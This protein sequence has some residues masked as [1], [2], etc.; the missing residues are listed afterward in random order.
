MKR[1]SHCRLSFFDSEGVSYEQY[2]A[3]REKTYLKLIPAAA[4]VRR[5]C[6]CY[7]NRGADLDAS[8]L[9]QDRK[10]VV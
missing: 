10:S 6:G 9:G 2:I 3:P 7:L 1:Q 5:F 8:D 4:A